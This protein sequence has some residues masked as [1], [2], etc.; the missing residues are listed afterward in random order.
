LEGVGV[1]VPGV[2]SEDG[3]VNQIANI[4]FLNNVNLISLLED[5][6]NVGVHLSKDSN[7]AAIGEGAYG[8]AKGM[9]NYILLTLGTGLGCS[10]VIDGK[11]LIGETGLAGEFG[12]AIIEKNGR[13]CGCG[14][15][16]CLEAYVSSTG[17]VR[18]VVELLAHKKMSSPLRDSAFNELT[19][20]LIFDAA[21]EGDS[22][23]KEA[24]LLTGQILGENIANLFTLFDP[25]AVIL[26][27]GL[28][29]ARTFLE[30]AIIEK[31]DCN[32]L[33]SLNNNLN[34]RFSSLGVNDAALL[35]A[36]TLI[37]NDKKEISI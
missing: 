25:E 14:R 15:F 30:P 24:F 13:E 33:Y 35:G 2:T 31:V 12:H 17:L 27:G 9:R 21:K 26:T 4:P 28:A 18:N 22:I 19:S 20:K 8:E 16:G 5:K 37:W 10:V 23:A 32:T 36:A 34:I 1:G 6:F 11:V 29:K 7:I 3:V